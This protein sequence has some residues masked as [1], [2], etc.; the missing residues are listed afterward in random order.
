MY[1]IYSNLTKFGI[2]IFVLLSALAG[3]L[4]SY[5]PELNLSV[6]HLFSLLIGTF[7]LSGGSLCLNQIQEVELDKKMNRTVLRPLASGQ[8]S[9]K[10]A[11]VICLS[12]LILG[13]ALLYYSSVLSMVLGLLVVIL[14]NG[15]YTYWWKPKWVFA[16]IPGAIP[17]ALPVTMGFA[18]NDSNI[19]QKDSIYIFLISFLW[20]MPHFWALA[21]KYKDDYKGID[22]P[23]LPVALGLPR[24]LYHMSLWTYSYGIVAMIS[25][26]LI[27][28]SW[29]YLL[30]VLPM[31]IK[32]L[33]EFHKFAQSNAE[34]NWMSFFIWIN[35]SLL[36]YIFVPALDKWSFLIF[37]RG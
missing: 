32:M 30:L 17:G 15:F 5:R 2:S 22:V 35:L 18:A 4:L 24:T 20:Q 10:T 34:K 19:F 3:Y 23:T 33:I 27:T 26:F 8:I 13:S 28:T 12:H 21:I 1:K 37:D 6:L 9:K 36:V 31:T 7:L 25:P 16:A 11:W 29:F 14:Y